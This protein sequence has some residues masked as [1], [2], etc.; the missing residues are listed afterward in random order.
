MAGKRRSDMEM[1]DVVDDV[2]RHLVR[3]RS[4]TRVA[5]IVAK[6]HGGSIRQAY[7]W[8]AM[9]HKKWEAESAA[10]G[11]A[12]RGR[13]RS[14]YRSVLN[15]ALY[16][17]MNRTET[18]R[19]EKGKPVL[20]DVTGKPVTRIVMDV[21]D[22]VRCVRQLAKLDGVDAPEA[23]LTVNLQGSLTHDVTPAGR[24]SL[25]AFLLGITKGNA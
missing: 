6:K 12:Q 16:N 22:V 13:L 10:D 11:H 25:K 1:Q 14:D 19:D 18:V 15:E 8:I 3:L 2:E 24:E 21:P 5:P 7:R 23:P 20:D 4:A 9:V 17:A